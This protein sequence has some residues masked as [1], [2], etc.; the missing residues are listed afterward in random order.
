MKAHALQSI[1]E[2]SDSDAVLV[3][4]ARSGQARA[5]AE[6]V[7]RHQSVARAVAYSTC[8]DV[9]L[10]EDLAQEAFVT[11]WMR[12]G[13]LQD[14]DKFRPWLA[15]IVRNTGRYWRRHQSRHAP[16]GSATVD[17]LGGIA[18][19]APSP[20]RQALAR[21]ELC[22]AS[23]ALTDLPPRY[24]EPL[25]LY[26]T[27]DESYSDVAIALDMSEA[28]ARQRI[29]RARKKLKAEVRSIETGARKLA[30]PTGVAASVLLAIE[31]RYAWATPTA[32]SG[33]A[34]P[35]MILSLGAM[36]ASALTVCVV[37]LLV[38]SSREKT[39][40]A[41]PASA[42]PAPGQR[43]Q[44]QRSEPSLGRPGGMPAAHSLDALSKVEPPRAIVRMG[45]GRVGDLD[46]R[47]PIARQ[48]RG[49]LEASAEVGA[50]A[51]AEAVAAPASQGRIRK[52]GPAVVLPP[53]EKPLL[54]PS[55][56]LRDVRRELWAD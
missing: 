16:R 46:R 5:F 25:V 14:P 32:A 23:R 17:E 28:A 22:E 52:H 30:R 29:C 37:A 27:L 26:Y 48:R 3:L 24:R 39:V 45:S 31:N 15:S 13:D 43:Q 12:L 7:E 34:T 41:A 10:S 42:S 18:C 1:G 51:S 36:C 49:K 11:A 19:D 56:D 8:G 6:L 38:L 2:H 47:V 53:E 35:K 21:Q 54:R 4:A 33:W 55:V 40:V 9:A 50:E 44:A 20:L